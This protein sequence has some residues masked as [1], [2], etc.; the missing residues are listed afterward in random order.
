MPEPPL[1]VEVNVTVVP[2]L[3]QNGPVLETEAVTVGRLIDTTV[4]LDPSAS[5]LFASS[6]VNVN[7]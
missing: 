3:A 2:G 4:A 5:Q 7:E 1:G 6:T